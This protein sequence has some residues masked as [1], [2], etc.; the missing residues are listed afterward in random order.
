MDIKKYT[1]A[2]RI[3]W[4]EVTPY[5]LKAKREWLYE[6]FG[7]PGFSCL[8]S[9]IT[10]KIREIG[11]E[12]KDV[13]QL[14]CNNGR[15]L[16][17]LKNLGSRRAVGFDIS[18][19]A[20]D[21]A[22]KL[23]Q[24][25]GVD[26]EFVRADIYELP[27]EFYSS[28]DLVYISIGALAWMPDLKAFFAIAASLLRKGGALLIYEMHPFLNMFDV[29]NQNDPLR[30]AESYFRSDPLIDYTS[31]D[32]Y[33]NTQYKAS[34]QYN[35][36]HTISDL[37]S[38]VVNNGLRLKLFEEYD[39]DISVCWEYLQNEKIKLPLSYILAAEK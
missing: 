29:E 25:A 31:L 35:F 32:Y 34:V 20:I 27:K 13:A 16:I 23:A 21:E 18:D 37:M 12:G 8:D 9:V 3:A 1:E 36:C 4:N 30:I 38:G 10:A 14:A 24:H 26:C 6:S 17:S 33:G 15:E 19:A 2:N 7:K 11:I 22:R 39:H 28:F 5:H